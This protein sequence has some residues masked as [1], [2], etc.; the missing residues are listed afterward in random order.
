MHVGA[1][2]GTI[3]FMNRTILIALFCAVT[4]AVS[5][6][7][8]NN[9]TNGLV[10]KPPRIWKSDALPKATVSKEMAS[11]LRVSDMTVVLQE[12]HMTDVQRRFGGTFGQEG[13]AAGSLEWL[14]LRGGDATG[15]WVL[16]LE[17]GEMDADTVGSFQWRRVTRGAKFD[18]RCALLPQANG[19]VGFPIALDLG[20]SEAK[21]LHVLGQPTSRQGNTLLYVH[22]HEGLDHKKPFTELNTASVVIRNGRVWAI[23]V[24]KISFAD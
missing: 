21:L 17:S 13:D 1:G 3:S 18:E 12:T 23:E 8:V 22:E 15:Q 4:G 5:G 19:G 20:T 6:Q 16:W 9:S 24:L 10:W 14:C 7:V 2:G 11:H